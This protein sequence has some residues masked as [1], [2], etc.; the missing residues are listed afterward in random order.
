MLANWGGSNPVGE[1]TV[2]QWIGGKNPL[3]LLA[4]N[5]VADCAKADATD[6]FCAVVNRE[7]V[8]PAWDFLDKGGSTS[9]RPLELLEGGIDVFNLTGENTCFTSFLG[10][11]RSSH[12]TTAQLKDFVLGPFEECGASISTNANDA[13]KRSRSASRSLI[14]NGPCDRLRNPTRPDRRVTFTISLDGGVA[15]PSRSRPHRRGAGR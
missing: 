8:D 11:T 5:L 4:D 9:I 10:S 15:R 1:L 7:T 12:S 6:N 3:A 13:D 14:G 2:Y